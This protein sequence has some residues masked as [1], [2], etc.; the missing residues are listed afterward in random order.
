MIFLSLTCPKQSILEHLQQIVDTLH[1]YKLNLN[2]KKYNF[3]TY[4][5]LLFG[6]VISSKEV[7]ADKRNGLSY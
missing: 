3:L 1:E 4:K 7:Q 2:L 5:L 6:F